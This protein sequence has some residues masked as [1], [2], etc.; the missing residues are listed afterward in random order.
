MADIKRILAEVEIDSLVF[1]S[2]YKDSMKR[3]KPLFN[4]QRRECELVIAGYS[5]KYRLAII[6]RWQGVGDS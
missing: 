4:L 3:Q 5:A 1:Q 6:D 2:I